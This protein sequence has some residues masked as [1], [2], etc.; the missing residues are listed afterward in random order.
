MFLGQKVH[1]LRPLIDLPRQTRRELALALAIH[2]SEPDVAALQKHR[3]KLIDPRQ[4]AGTPARYR[5]FISGSRAEFGIAKSGYVASRSGWFSDRSAC[6][7]ACG[8]PVLAHNTGFDVALPTGEGLLA[9]SNA[10]DV[11]AGMDAIDADYPRHRSA[12]RALAET[13]LDSDRVL[14]RLLDRV[15]A[16]S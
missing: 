1:A 8:R 3:W 16:A 10:S 4:A 7:L 13:Y 14:T 2:P 5:R 15:G 12:A 6:Y 11:V 9:F